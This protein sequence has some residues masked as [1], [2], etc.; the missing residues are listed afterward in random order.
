LPERRMSPLGIVKRLDVVKDIGAGFIA[1]SG[2]VAV[3][4]VSR[5]CL[6]FWSAVE[7]YIWDWRVQQGIE[8]PARFNFGRYE[9]WVVGSNRGAPDVQR[10]ANIAGPCHLAWR[11]YLT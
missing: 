6:R 2:D 4:V 11:M 8:L 7:Y 1:G 3:I 9:S 5:S 10:L